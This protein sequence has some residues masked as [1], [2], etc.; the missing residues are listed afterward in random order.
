MEEE[1]CVLPVVLVAGG[2]G[3]TG[4][5]VVKQLA[6]SNAYRVR[7]LVRDEEKAQQLLGGLAEREGSSR[8]QFV[9]GS[10]TDAS[11]PAGL[12]KDVQYVIFAAGTTPF[13]NQSTNS[14]YHVGYLGLKKLLE[15]V[16]KESTEDFR[17]F[18]LISSLGVERPFFFVT[19]LLNVIGN[20]VMKWKLRGENELRSSGLPYLIVRP[21]GLVDEAGGRDELV[22]AQGDNISGRVTRAD[23]AQVCVEALS[24]SAVDNCTFEL[25]AKKKQ[26]QNEGGEGDGE[27]NEEYWEQMFASL[28]KDEGMKVPT[29]SHSLPFQLFGGVVIGLVAA[30]AAWSFGL[31]S[32]S[33]ASSS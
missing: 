29:F 5:E 17:C 15:Q 20:M 2:T 27:R 28:K 22:F 7:V 16:K 19:M 18:V 24:Y 8:L 30:S 13:K 9:H 14:E 31:W 11:L 3:R 33:S 23:V 10:L 25:I 1:R 6:A 12:C 4:A 32:S 26:K 21:G